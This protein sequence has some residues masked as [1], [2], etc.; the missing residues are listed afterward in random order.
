[1]YHRLPAVWWNK[2]TVL[3][4]WRRSVTN[5]RLTTSRGDWVL[6]SGRWLPF[7]ALPH[8]SSLEHQVS[9]PGHQDKPSSLSPTHQSLTCS[10]LTSL[11][12]CCSLRQPW[13]RAT[14]SSPAT[15][16]SALRAGSSLIVACPLTIVSKLDRYRSS[17]PARLRRRCRP[18]EHWMHGHGRCA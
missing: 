5:L 16:V 10:S 3:V 9:K 18:M 12:L 7:L 14:S 2:G 17:R 6:K 4:S 15:S 11:H 8:P 1:M 13:A